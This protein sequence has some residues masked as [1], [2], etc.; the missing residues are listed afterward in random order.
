MPVGLAAL[1]A[2]AIAAALISFALLPFCFRGLV[3]DLN[4]L[5]TPILIHGGIWMGIGAVGGWAFGT[6]MSSRRH[7]LNAL[8]AASVGG[9][10]A[11]V[12]YH[13]LTGS[14]FPDVSLTEPV[15][16]SVV[17]RLIAMVLVTVLI[18]VGAASGS[19]GRHRDRTA[20]PGV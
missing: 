1:A 6:G 3:P 12:L 14:L 9:F 18:A 20:R 16:K 7:I 15:A 11:S 10:V 5:M 17:V 2:G 13:L 19:M 8:G 4:D